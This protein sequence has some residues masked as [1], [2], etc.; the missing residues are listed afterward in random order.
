[1][2]D[3]VLTEKHFKDVLLGLDKK[4]DI[5]I[6]GEGPQNVNDY[7]TKGLNFEV[8]GAISNS[9]L[10]EHYVQTDCTLIP[11]IVSGNIPRTVMESLAAGTPLLTTEIDAHRKYGWFC[12]L[13][14]NSLVYTIDTVSRKTAAMSKKCREYALKMFSDKNFEKISSLYESLLN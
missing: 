11:H 1:M 2:L 3:L 14:K 9:Q 5:K 12:D 10:N 4:F 8:I 13:E 6:I 7:I